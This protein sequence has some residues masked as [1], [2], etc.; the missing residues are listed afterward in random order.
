MNMVNEFA[1]SA[2]SLARNPLGIIALFIVLVYA[3]ASVVISFAKPEFYQ[4][5][6]HPAVWFLTIFPCIVL[7][8][9]TYLVAKHHRK[10]YGPSDDS[11]QKDFLKTLEIGDVPEEIR[12]E[13]TEVAT[14]DKTTHTISSDTVNLL[15]AAYQ[16]MVGSGYCLLHAAQVLAERTAPRTGRYRLRVWIEPIQGRPLAE[17]ESVTYRVW[18]DFSPRHY[19][20]T[21]VRS[22]FD[23]W[24]H[25]YGEF[26]VIAVLKLK[27]GQT[28]QLQ[29]YLDIPGRPPD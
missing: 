5:A 11:D 26:P 12:K 13:T 28:I 27:E 17:I 7:F 22:N 16:E 24:L 15:D 21:S 2:K 1:D 18:D 20:T 10:L 9:F 4:H 29:R 25:V 23:L 19:T 8:V 6:E 14:S 3:M